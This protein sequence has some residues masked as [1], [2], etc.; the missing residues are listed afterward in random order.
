MIRLRM[1]PPYHPGLYH[2]S[3]WSKFGCHRWSIF[4]CHFYTFYTLRWRVEICAFFLFPINFFGFA[5]AIYRC[6]TLLS[7]D[8][9]DSLL[10][11]VFTAGLVYL[12]KVIRY[13]LC[14]LSLSG[15][16]YKV[17]SIML[18][19]QTSLETS[20]VVLWIKLVKLNSIHM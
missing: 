6:L 14:D 15:L 5:L 13:Q 4:G 19:V 1:I 20:S 9:N 7:L 12:R 16:T 2:S 18:K 17:L 10:V 3:G 11:L 8:P